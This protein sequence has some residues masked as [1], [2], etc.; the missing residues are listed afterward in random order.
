MNE[1]NL[2]K[3]D[4]IEELKKLPSGSIDVVISS[5]PYWA[6]RNY[7]TTG[8]IGLEDH[9]QKY[10]EKIF[11]VMKECK[12]VIKPTGSI[13]LNLGDSY[14]T[15]SGSGTGSNF[16]KRHEQLDGGDGVLT[17]AHNEIRGKYK[18]NWLQSKQRL[19]I[20]YRL[21][22]KC[23]DELGLI[24]RNEI[25]W[26]KSIIN[27]KTKESSGSSMP[28]SV[29]DRLN[30]T[31]EVIFFF[32]KSPKH[33]YFDLDS[34]RIPH[35]SVSIKRNSYPRYADTK[36]QGVSFGR[37][38]NPGEMLSPNGK[39]PGN[40]IMF[41]LEP[42]KLGHYAMFPQTLP[43]FFIKACCPEFVCNKCGKPRFKIFKKEKVGK[44]ESNYNDGY[45]QSGLQWKEPAK[46]ELVGYTD[47]GC[48]K[49]FSPGLVLDPFNGLATTGLV[50]LKNKRRY[51]GIDLNEEYL[52]LSL[53]RVKPYLSQKTL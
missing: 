26:V 22:I 46:K 16:K 4:C 10:I 44:T 33:Y 20:P 7:K 41:P 34:I 27:W 31:N 15:K 2:I 24:L 23:Q 18:S 28:S 35:K 37:P 32:V 45:G 52:K 3:G 49:G 51:I 17:K 25:I 38:V 13:I 43:E 39:N 1:F 9:P 50:A 48:N 30:T 5:P 19:L 6:L 8:Q 53:E 42:S 47:C 21:A 40:C 29:N 14:Y 36:E 12:R 11:E